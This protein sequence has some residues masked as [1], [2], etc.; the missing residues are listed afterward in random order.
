MAEAFAAL[1]KARAEADTAATEAKVLEA[2]LDAAAT[3]AS[4]Y[5]EA[6]NSISMATDGVSGWA[7]GSN[8]VLLKTVDGGANWSAVSA[9]FLVGRVQF[10]DDEAGWVAGTRGYDI[11]YFDHE[12][13]ERITRP[14]PFVFEGP[15]DSSK[16]FLVNESCVLQGLEKGEIRL[17]MD[18]PSGEGCSRLSVSG[19]S[20]R[21][22]VARQSELLLGAASLEGWTSTT[23]SPTPKDVIQAL[24]LTFDGK[25]GW[26][27]TESGAI[28]STNDDG[29]TWQ[30][31]DPGDI[32]N[33]QHLK[34]SDSGRQV[35]AV[36]GTEILSS[37]D[38]G[39]SWEKL[40]H[41]RHP[42]RWLYLSWCVIGFVGFV[43]WNQ[44]EK[45]RDPNV[46]T[47]GDEMDSDQPV[48]S[49]HQDKL[50]FAPIVS[51]LDNFIRNEETKPPVTIAINGDWGTGKSSLMSMLVDSLRRR[52]SY[53]VWF[54][55]WHH[56]S[57]QLTLVPF[58]QHV[59]TQAVPPGLT[60]TGLR[61]RLRLAW[62]R[63]LRHPVN[64]GLLLFGIVLPLA[65][66]AFHDFTQFFAEDNIKV[67][68]SDLGAVLK[69]F[70]VEKETID[71]AS[72]AIATLISPTSGKVFWILLMAIPAWILALD[73]L[74]AF[75]EVPA[76]LFAT[77]R[78]KFRLSEAEAQ[79]SFRQN[80]SRH[81][82]DVIRA[83]QPQPVVV[84]VDDIDRCTKENAMEML[85]CA[86]FLVNAGPCFVVL[87]LARER[88]E[89]LVGLA[90]AEFAEETADEEESDARE[91]RR[92]YARQYLEKLIQVEINVPTPPPAALLRVLGVEKP[93]PADPLK[94]PPPR[95]PFWLTYRQHITMV[96][97]AV[98]F[99]AVAVWIGYSVPGPVALSPDMPLLAEGGTGGGGAAPEPQPAPP[100]STE[101]V[102][103]ANPHAA[104]GAP[105]LAN[106]LPWI[107]LLGTAGVLTWSILRMPQD[108]IIRNSAAYKAAVA[109]WQPLI[110]RRRSTPR[111]VKQ[112]GNMARYAAM[113]MRSD[114][115]SRH[116][117]EGITA[118][119]RAQGITPDSVVKTETAAERDE[120][121]VALCAIHHANRDFFKGETD[122]LFKKEWEDALDLQVIYLRNGLEKLR[123]EG[124]A[125]S[126]AEL[127]LIEAESML[128][129]INKIIPQATKSWPPRDQSL[130]PK[131]FKYV[132]AT[133]AV[134][135]PSPASATPATPPGTSPPAG[136]PHSAG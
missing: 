21:F 124:K 129:T 78:D 48:V 95:P 56:Q 18:L 77:W 117:I 119:E 113:M 79:A 123:S 98:L 82:D 99:A 11:A 34:V 25:Q 39:N 116:I 104:H 101:A 59:C 100:P 121:I 53:P 10:G 92:F 134:E 97:C 12:R 40:V 35:L 130:K 122:W 38:G 47:I 62:L 81:F 110:A 87:G 58:L 132:V 27:G 94:P 20:S 42:A 112:F 68:L 90:N 22:M 128:E 66:F 1:D 69:P 5:S 3:A 36:T 2:Q 9:P 51:A 32:V 133:F 70:G 126:A 86:N 73:A 115:E 28:L 19:D 84:F 54:N 91:N 102:V 106:F 65:Y 108:L 67:V 29:A 13:F 33:V 50:D 7:A 4:D 14:F 64:L 76:I 26:V 43:A 135:E 75:P 136:A 89:A 31:R 61:F 96:C 127:K 37:G 57:E 105:D 52:G 6:L 131:F 114:T 72:T 93:K 83:L 30:R 74:R 17:G 111:A 103:F 44:G 55:A 63:V 23:P 45:K 8:G 85:E 46:E 80:F 118:E 71:D 24:A 125:G 109:A 15:R 41:R 88:V 107:I 16:G 49:L 120:Q 60:R